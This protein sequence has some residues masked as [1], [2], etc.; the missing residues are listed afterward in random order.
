MFTKLFMTALFAK[1]Q[2]LL[3]S[4]G[5]HNEFPQSGTVGFKQQKLTMLQFWRLET[6][7]Q[8]VARAI[9]SFENTRAI[10]SCFF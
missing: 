7:I 2:K 8:G 4:Q 3:I 5:R 10:L 6:W 9:G 1:D